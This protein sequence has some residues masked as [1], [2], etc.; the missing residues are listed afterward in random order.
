MECGSLAPGA[1]EPVRR[2]GD[3]AVPELKNLFSPVTINR[4]KLANRAVM[5]AMGTGY[6]D[7]E[8]NATDRLATYLARRAKGGAGLL[9]TEVCAVDRRGKGFPS[10]I[11]AWSDDLI[12]SLTRIA[13]AV[14]GV[15]GRVA[16]Q[17]HHA[18]RETFEAFAGGTPETKPQTSL[19]TL[20]LLRYVPCSRHS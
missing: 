12:P 19:L 2:K 3:Q 10:E 15:G 13:E 14:H 4:L 7:F 17:L 1:R 18:G 6:G 5:P 20:A 16:L 11:G 9:I 8:G